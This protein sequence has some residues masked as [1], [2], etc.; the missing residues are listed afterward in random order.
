MNKDR[1]QSSHLPEAFQTEPSDVIYLPNSF[2]QIEEMSPLECKNGGRALHINYSFF[3]TLFGEMMMASTP[4]GVCYIGFSN[5]KERLMRELTRLFPKA[6]YKEQTDDFQQKA[7]LLFSLEREPSEPIKLHLKGTNFQLS[8]WKALL[9]IP[10]GTLTSYAKIARQVDKP[11]A[12]RA[13]G[14]SVG[15]NPVSFLIPCH[16]VVCSNGNLGGYHWGLP[17]KI[18]MIEW[19]AAQLDDSRVRMN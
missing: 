18:T 6:T 12:S 2:I 8:V 14:T 9:K 5:D 19:E 15:S 7:L 1:E 4:K 17:R 11:K 13:V 3:N 10:F 16:R